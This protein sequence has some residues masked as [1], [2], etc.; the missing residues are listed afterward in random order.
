MYSQNWAAKA[1]IWVTVRN[2][3]TELGSQGVY[4]AAIRNILTELGS[5]GVYMG[6]SKKCTYR[7]G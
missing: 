5:Q 7:A 6:Y 4:M 2:V 3:L 1:C